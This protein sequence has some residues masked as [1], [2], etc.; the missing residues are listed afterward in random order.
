MGL[1]L[2]Q[3]FKACGCGIQK[4]RNARQRYYTLV[5]CGDKHEEPPCNEQHLEEVLRFKLEHRDGGF[6][7]V[8]RWHG[9]LLDDEEEL[10]DPDDECDSECESGCDC[11]FC[12][13]LRSADCFEGSDEEDDD[14]DT[15]SV[16]SSD[17]DAQESGR[18]LGTLWY[19]I[20]KRLRVFWHQQ[21]PSDI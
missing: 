5:S 10:D 15:R 12:R 14:D 16:A 18:H 6:E 3:N 1:E 21:P 9:L 13:A 11:Q 2:Y 8:D 17:I 19:M 20:K 7:A 4:A